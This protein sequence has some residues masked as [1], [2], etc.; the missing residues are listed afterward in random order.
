MDKLL[1][2]ILLD[3]LLDLYKKYPFMKD[4]GARSSMTD[5]LVA[6]EFYRAGYNAAIDEFAKQLKEEIS[7]RYGT[8]EINCAYNAK[9]RTFKVI[10]EIV[11][12]MKI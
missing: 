5:Q 10:D 11:V 3:N 9:E 7:Y 2:E 6:E 12:Q 4:N 1:D 8:G